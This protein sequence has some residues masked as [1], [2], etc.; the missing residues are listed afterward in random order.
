MEKRYRTDF[1]F[2]T[3]SFFSGAARVLDIGGTFDVYNGSKSTEEADARALNN[4]L[5]V[6]LQDFQDA[7]FAARERLEVNE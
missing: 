4:D 2:A 6:I 7:V 3:P 1:L 5:S